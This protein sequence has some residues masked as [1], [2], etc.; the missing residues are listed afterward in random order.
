MKNPQIVYVTG[1]LGFIGSHVTRECLQR[2]W[3]V[4]GVDSMTYASNNSWLAEFEPNSHFK[5]LHKDINDLDRLLDSDVIINAA[6]ETHVDNSIMD[7][8]V[9][10]H[11]NVMGIHRLLELMRR[12]PA[13]RRPRF[14]QFSTDEVYGDISR[15]SHCETDTL[16]PSNPYSASKA[17]ADQ[18]IMAW[19]R[20]YDIQYNILRPSNNYGIGQYVEKLIPKSIKYLELGHEIDLHDRGEPCRVW[21]HAKDTAQAVMSVIDHGAVNEIYNIS[22][23]IELSNRDVIKKI[24]ALYFGESKDHEWERYTRPSKRKGQDVRYHVNDGRLRALGWLPCADFDQELIKIVDYYRRN[25]VW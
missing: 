3:H 13:H 18:L 21:L 24:L 22:G 4:I 19:G 6:A 5:F 12:L 10:M 11:S 14:V 8:D 7:N 2:G 16:R 15:G 25:F 9:F 20:T 23:N 17:C 1:C